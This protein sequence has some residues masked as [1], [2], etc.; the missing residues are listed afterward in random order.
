MTLEK[1]QAQAEMADA[2]GIE[3]DLKMC[4]RNWILLAWNVNR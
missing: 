4:A 1:R 2:D 3:A